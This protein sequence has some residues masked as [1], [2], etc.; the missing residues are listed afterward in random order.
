MSK[1]DFSFKFFLV[2]LL[3]TVLD[4]HDVHFQDKAAHSPAHFS[5]Y[6]NFVT[7]LHIPFSLTMYPLPSGKK[8]QYSSVK[9]N[10]H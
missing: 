2:V 4:F 1:N 6:G 7:A 10:V 5:R 3:D 8:L 9:C